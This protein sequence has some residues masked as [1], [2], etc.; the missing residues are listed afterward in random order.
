MQEIRRG[1]YLLSQTAIHALRAIGFVAKDGK[2]QPVL[3]SRISE[4]LDIPQNFLSKI[5]HRLVQEGYLNSKRGTNGGFTLAKKPN[6]ITIGE[7]VSL[8]MNIKQFDQCFLG[9]SKCDGS[10]GLHSQ[11]KPIMVAFRKLIDENTIDKLF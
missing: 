9:G 4:E 11:W 6:K 5:M 7:I 10:C 3:S 2:D 8:F 1:D